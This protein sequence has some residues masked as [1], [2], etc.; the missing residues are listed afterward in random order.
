MLGV[1]A[2]TT[3]RDGV[4]GD[5]DPAILGFGSSTFGDPI[6]GNQLDIAGYGTYW[7][8]DTATPGQLNVFEIS[9]DLAADL[10]A[11]QFISGMLPDTALTTSS[12]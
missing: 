5:H 10:D 1:S 4:G 9:L 6:L 2:F 8:V 7:A 12:G 11:L 3:K